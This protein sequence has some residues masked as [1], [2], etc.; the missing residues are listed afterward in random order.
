[1]LDIKIIGDRQV[2]IAFD[3]M[4]KETP[5]VLGRI[6]RKAGLA[7]EKRVKENLTNRILN[8][9]SGQLRRSI[10]TR[11][12][13]TS[14]SPFAEI[15]TNLIY[16]PVHEFGATIHAKNGPY[17]KFKV[18]TKGMTRKGGSWVSVPQVT[19]PARPFM[20]TSFK[21]SIPLIERIANEE[22]DKLVK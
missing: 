8:V 21:E 19:I 15:G 22:A 3:Q 1:M 16:A 12:G 5:K 6:I 9:Q 18:G 17:L 11:F 4:Q 13:G 20:Q 14:N 2:V 10:T 7:V